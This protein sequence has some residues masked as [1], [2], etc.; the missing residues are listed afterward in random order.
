MTD[1]D[2]RRPP[3][4]RCSNR[5]AAHPDQGLSGLRWR[6]SC[7]PSGQ[8]SDFGSEITHSGSWCQR[9]KIADGSPG[10]PTATRNPCCSPA[11]SRQCGSR[12][13]H[14]ACRGCSQYQ[15]VPRRGTDLPGCRSDRIR[16]AHRGCAS[17]ASAAASVRLFD[18]AR[19]ALHLGQSVVEGVFWAVPVHESQDGIRRSRHAPSLL[20]Q[21]PCRL[22]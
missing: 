13:W 11:Y 20:Q 2:R 22:A 7:G 15:D 8:R 18:Q 9:G 19:N 17:R 21:T 12:R 3:L 4:C 1:S 5:T 10:Q 6:L 16:P 14:R